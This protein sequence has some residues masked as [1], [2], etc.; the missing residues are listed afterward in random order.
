MD[1]LLVSRLQAERD[2]RA[3]LEVGLS[4][5]SGQFSSSRGMDSKPNRDDEYARIEV[6]GGKVIQGNGHRVFGVLAMSRSIV[7]LEWIELSVFGTLPHPRCGHSAT[8]VEK[9]LLVYGG[10]GG[11]GPIMG[12]LWALKGLIEEV[13]LFTCSFYMLWREENEAPGWTPL[14]LPGQAPSPRCG[15]TVVSGGHYL[16]MFGGHGIGGWL[17]RYDIYYNDCIILDR[18]S[19]QWTRLPIGNEPPPTRAYHSM[20]VIGSRYLLTGGFD[21]KSTYGDPWWLVPK[22]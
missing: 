6:A 7:L 1:L 16:L 18:V 17:S 14:K 4:M 20:T 12:D 8:M 3:S 19:A 21:G 5:S 2:L 15:H 11:G 10:R 9:R 22:G 13:R